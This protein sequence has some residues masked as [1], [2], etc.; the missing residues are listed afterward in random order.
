[1]R[2]MGRKPRGHYYDQNVSWLQGGGGG[3]GGS[4][5]KKRTNGQKAKRRDRKK[6]KGVVSRRWARSPSE[7]GDVGGLTGGEK[8]RDPPKTLICPRSGD[9][10]STMA[11]RGTSCLTK[12]NHQGRIICLHGH[13]VGE[14]TKQKKKIQVAQETKSP[15]STLR[16]NWPKLGK[17]KTRA[18]L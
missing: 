12:K 2:R 7:G 13:Y 6:Q 1:M 10:G 3:G 17:G 14:L 5:N 15:T 9:P 16:S 4:E 11:T 8:E 18:Q